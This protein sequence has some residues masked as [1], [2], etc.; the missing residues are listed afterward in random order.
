[1]YA[2][3]GETYL[4]IVICETP[5]TKFSQSQVSHQTMIKRKKNI[6]SVNRISIF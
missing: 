3:N 1:M 5:S 6:Y 2:E 4:L